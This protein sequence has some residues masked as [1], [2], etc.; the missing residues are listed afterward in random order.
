MAEL[1]AAVVHAAVGGGGVPVD[2]H[3]FG[4]G[5]LVVEAGV[6]AAEAQREVDGR[7]RL[8]PAGGDRGEALLPHGRRV[9]GAGAEHE[10]AGEI[11]LEPQRPPVQDAGPRRGRRRRARDGVLERASLQVG[12]A[13]L[14]RGR[15]QVPA[16]EGGDVQ[17]VAGVSAQHV[18]AHAGHSG[19][20][21]AVDQGVRLRVLD[22]GGEHPHPLRDHETAGLEPP[23]PGAFHGADHRAAEAGQAEAFADQHV[24]EAGQADVVRRALHD[25]HPR[26][27]GGGQR[28][29]PGR[30]GCALD[31]DHGARARPGGSDGEHPGAGAEIDNEVRRPHRP[32]HGLDEGTGAHLVRQQ[33]AVEAHHLAGPCVEG[34]HEPYAAGRRVRRLG[35]QRHG[36]PRRGWYRGCALPCSLECPASLPAISTFLALRA[37]L[38]FVVGARTGVVTRIRRFGSAFDLDTRPHIR[39]RSRIQTICRRAISASTPSCCI[40]A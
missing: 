4:V 13:H 26:A 1:G 28:L 30:D 12:A 33:V 21:E 17:V 16:G 34:R 8:D 3:A 15:E 32:A 39:T 23:V 36:C 20:V 6:S 31:A 27:V 24:G 22:G 7:L 40:S 19:A 11:R 10:I 35:G 14:H 5:G 18:Q 9:Q 37:G 25:R 38:R 29:S 2:P